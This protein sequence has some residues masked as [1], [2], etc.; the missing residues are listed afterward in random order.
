MQN[1]FTS[2][3]WLETRQTHAPGGMHKYAHVCVAYK[4][5]QATYIAIV[6]V[7]PTLLHK[8]LPLVSN[9]TIILCCGFSSLPNQAINCT[10]L[11][12]SSAFTGEAE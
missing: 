5:N 12:F 9:K 1:L 6:N 8:H 4:S 11:A 2:N 10:W 3:V 7:S